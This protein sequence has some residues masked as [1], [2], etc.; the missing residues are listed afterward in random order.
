MK[1]TEERFGLAYVIDVLRGSQNERIRRFGHDRLSTWGIGKSKPKEEWQYLGRALMRD[2]Y[3]RTAPEA[4]NA[5][6]IT[7]RGN[8]ILFKGEQL[9]LPAPNLAAKS[10]RRDR[11]DTDTADQPNPQLFEMLRR[12][13][14]QLADERRVPPYVVFPDTTLR[15]MAASL[16]TTRPDLLRIIGVGEKKAQEY[17]DAFI[18][19]IESYTNQTRARPAELPPRKRVERRADDLSPSIRLSADLFMRGS[20][21]EEIA[22]DRGMAA[23][24]IEAHIV[25]ALEAGLD[26][27]IDLLVEPGKRAAIEAAMQRVGDELMR[28]IMDELGDGFT[29]SDIRFA[30][31]WRRARES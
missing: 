1:R 17:G 13:R 20:S 16:P 6:R 10:S 27:N 24:T 9:F 15:H 29:W 28:P 2:G 7:S 21:I 14:K 11:G 8:E 22:E 31:A 3:I 30:R 18:G 25:E 12:L 23:S 19:V 4:Y 26:L 5:A